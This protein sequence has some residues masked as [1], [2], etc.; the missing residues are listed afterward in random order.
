[1]LDLK[2]NTAVYLLYAHARIAGIVRKANKD[3]Q[4]LARE[5]T[6]SLDHPKE[7]ELALHLCKFTGE[8]LLQCLVL[9]CLLPCFSLRFACSVPGGAAAGAA[10]VQ[11]HRSK[12]HCRWCLV[13]S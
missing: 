12:P 1:M 5:A 2:G 7:Q 4:Q 8:P 6:I 3:V 13:F 10:P 9:R 11:V